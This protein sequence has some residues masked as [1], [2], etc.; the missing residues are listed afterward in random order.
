[1][2]ETRGKRSLTQY[3][4]AREYGALP[5]DI[6]DI[7]TRH[8]LAAQDKATRDKA[9]ED[10]D[11]IFRQTQ[12][13]KLRDALREVV[14]PVL[15]EGAKLL[16]REGYSTRVDEILSE[17]PFSGLKLIA[18]EIYLETQGRNQAANGARGKYV[19]SYKGDVERFNI[20]G[21]YIL[22]GQRT[23][24][25]DAHNVP[26]IDLATP[27]I[28]SQFREFVDEALRVDRGA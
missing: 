22:N 5:M 20:N 9:I 28:E 7:V 8:N 19:L 25:K 11:K 6:S 21:S 16:S 13:L 2:Q 26:V 10:G 1:M 15:R 24:L 12:A 4:G 23:L 14:G 17:D 27:L 3:L 18:L